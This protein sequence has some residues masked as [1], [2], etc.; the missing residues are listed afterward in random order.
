MFQY[1][2]NSKLCITCPSQLQG[3]IRNESFDPKNWMIPGDTSGSYSLSL[4]FL[5]NTRSIYITGRRKLKRKIIADVVEAL[6]GAYLSA[7]GEI[8]ALL[9]LNWLGIKVD[10]FNT[11]YEPQFKV[12]PEKYINIHGLES[13]LNYSFKNH[14]LLL[15]A[16]THGSYML[17]EIPRCYQVF[18]VPVVITFLPFML[19]CCDRI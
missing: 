3:F 12:N 11:P 17:P 15:E 13:L 8:A 2:S 1:P 4:E 18:I 16:L 6:I 14:Y 7:G 9:F 19:L 10:F 5:S